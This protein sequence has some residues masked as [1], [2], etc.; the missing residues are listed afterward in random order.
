MVKHIIKKIHMH[1]LY[2]LKFVYIVVF[3]VEAALENAK[4]TI[5]ERLE[6]ETFFTPPQPW[7]GKARGFLSGKFFVI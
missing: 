1:N 4:L 3:D 2:L 7:L 5:L 6:L